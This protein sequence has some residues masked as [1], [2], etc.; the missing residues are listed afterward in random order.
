MV[1]LG[2][3]PACQP[4]VDVP[5]LLDINFP[6]SCNHGHEE[7]NAKKG[8]RGLVMISRW[9]TIKNREASGESLYTKP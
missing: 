3:I 9:K 7:G 1:R 5:K 2:S 4:D 6:S 8:G